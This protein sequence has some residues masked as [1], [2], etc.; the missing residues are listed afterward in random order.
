M[1]A[2]LLGCLWVAVSGESFAHR[3]DEYLQATRVSVATN[4][5]DFTFELTPGVEVAGQVLEQMDPDR[6]G[7][8]SQDEGNAYAQRFLNDLKLSL[9]GNPAAIKVTSASF[10]PGQEIRK[11]IGTIRIQATSD[12][13]SLGAGSHALQLS[14]GHLPAISVYL[15]NALQSNDPLVEIG[16]QTRDEL[17]KDYRLEFRIRRAKP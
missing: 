5:I 11:G 2:V 7:R 15:V 13:P 1:R 12:A 17:Q 4:R 3:L 16:K 9:D 8:I 14:N 10:P 6:D